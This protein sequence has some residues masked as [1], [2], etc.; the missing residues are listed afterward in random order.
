VEEQ[1]VLERRRELTAERG[2]GLDDLRFVPRLDVQALELQHAQRA[3]LASQ[4]DQQRGAP[5][6]SSSLRRERGGAVPKRRCS[7]RDRINDG[8]A[9]ELRPMAA[10]AGRS[11][12]QFP[13]VPVVQPRG[14]ASRNKD[15]RTRSAD[16][17]Q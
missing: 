5:I 12:Q 6:R 15:L 7:E 1:D 10:L 11:K 13:G 14:C 2:G 9:G 8:H 16:G 17:C 3:A 4:R